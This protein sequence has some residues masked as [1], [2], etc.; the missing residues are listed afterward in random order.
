MF[1]NIFENLEIPTQWKQSHIVNLYKG[2]GDPELMTN[3]RGITLS[4]SFCKLYE[5]II[6]NRI[7]PQLEY[8]ELQAGGRASY[9][10]L[11]Q[12]FILQSLINQAIKDKKKLYIVL[13]DIQKAYDKTWGEIIWHNLWKSGIK[14]KIWRTI[15][16]LN[17]STTTE[18]ITKFGLTDPIHL[19]NNLKQGSILGVNE[20]SNMMDYLGKLLLE[21]NLGA[22]YNDLRI[23]ALL[24]MD[25][26]AI[27]EN[28]KDRL[29]DSLDIVETFRKKFKLEL[30]D[31]KC[32][33]LITYPDL[34]SSCPE[35]VLNIHTTIIGMTLKIRQISFL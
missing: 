24:F 4:N 11:D 33:I 16:K 30:S 27:L 3:Q 26:I 22:Q 13:I 32:Q 10:T 20:F 5:K 7:K 21:K 18:I 23:P 1:N 35:L 29:I 17:E 6:D 12:L 2:K 31:T 19:V 25:D 28:N 9:S 15:K 8:T 34:N 14:G